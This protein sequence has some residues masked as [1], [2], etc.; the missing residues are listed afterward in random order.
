MGLQNLDLY[1]YDTRFFSQPFGQ[2]C[3]VEFMNWICILFLSNAG[4]GQFCEA[5]LAKIDNVRQCY[6]FVNYLYLSKYYRKMLYGSTGIQY[7]KCGNILW[8][9]FEAGSSRCLFLL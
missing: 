4:A 6:E 1:K 9:N 3:P 2:L 5:Y 8:L 7:D